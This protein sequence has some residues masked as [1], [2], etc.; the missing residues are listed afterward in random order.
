MSKAEEVAKTLEILS[1]Q[2][3]TSELLD[4]CNSMYRGYQLKIVYLKDELIGV[5]NHEKFDS[6]KA[7][8]LSELIDDYY[9]ILKVIE[10][11]RLSIKE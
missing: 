9:N 8:A 3:T 1:K 4:A 11:F 7:I 2:K 6:E 5:V 10:D